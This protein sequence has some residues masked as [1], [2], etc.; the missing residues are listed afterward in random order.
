MKT[1]NKHYQQLTQEQ[2]Y[3]TSGLRKAGMTQAAIAE[4]VAVCSSTIS[5]ELK[6]NSTDNVYDPKRAHVQSVSR[7]S[8]ASKAQTLFLAI[9]DEFGR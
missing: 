4:A 7:R 5:R 3:Q 8:S 9:K 2:R 1:H 6:R